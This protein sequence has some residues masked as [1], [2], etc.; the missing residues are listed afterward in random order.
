MSDSQNQ[1]HHTEL[2]TAHAV[3]SGSGNLYIGGSFAPSPTIPLNGSN[4]PNRHP[5]FVGRREELK[6]V[7]D[8]LASRAWI[9][10]IDGMGGIGKTTLAL[11]ATHLCKQRDANYPNVPEFT[12]YI[13]TSARDR[14][15]FSL[16]DVVREVL[17]VLSPF[18]A[19]MKQ[20]GLPEQ[21]S[22]AI[23]ALA[24]EPRLLIIDNFET[25]KDESLH[26]FLRDQLPNPSK[27]LITSR[28]HL[29]TGEK[30]VTIG[31]LE[32]EDAIQL[33]KLE[34]ARLNI[35]ISDQDITRLLIIAQ[36]SFGIPLV[37]R[38]AME[39]VYNGK[40]LE[41]V[42]ESLEDATAEDIFDY[43]F[44][45]SLSTL[46]IETRNI[47]RSMALLPTWGRI[48]TIAAMN[49]H[50]AAIQERVGRLVSLSLLDDN[51][52]LV[53]SDRRYQLPSFARYL[54]AKE[55]NDSED[56][57]RSPIEH[58]LQQYLIELQEHTRYDTANKYLDL[59]FINIGSIV[60]AASSLG[61]AALIE[62][63]I[64]TGNLIRRFNI[65]TA[66]VLF[67]QIIERIDKS[68]DWSL[69]VRLLRHLNPFAFGIPV[70]PPIFYGRTKQLDFIQNLLESG[71]SSS[72]FI[73]LIGPRR[74]G[75]TS[76]LL[77]L[78]K[79]QSTR[80]EYVFIDLQNP[81]TRGKN[82]FYYFLARSVSRV[83]HR[84][85]ETEDPTTIE[86][87][88]QDF[89]ESP[90]RVLVEYLERVSPRLGNR[91]LVLMLDELEY[92]F[93]P[94]NQDREDAIEIQALFRFMLQRGMISLITAGV[95][96]L[97]ELTHPDFVSPLFNTSMVMKLSFLDREDAIALITNPLT[98]LVKFKPEAIER[99][100]EL[101][102]RHPFLLQALGS[103]V[104][105]ICSEKEQLLV[106]IEIVNIAASRVILSAAAYFENMYY[107]VG[108]AGQAVLFAASSFV[109]NINETFSMEELGKVMGKELLAPSQ[110]DEA[111][112]QLLRHEIIEEDNDGAYR[113]TMDITRH[114]AAEKSRG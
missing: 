50:T 61:D 2:Q 31:G 28:H 54:A 60:K 92:L 42:V 5:N 113:F 74:I 43:I 45:L 107:Q 24:T 51:R 97:S 102:G 84:D 39:S 99:L 40:S 36:K 10:T 109:K 26:R 110:I 37:L 68:D 29:Q 85:I 78:N 90:G 80:C 17:Y 79:R 88:R 67:D 3:H 7:I 103:E 49:P 83:L 41:W 114:W 70:T 57:G 72:P 104:V 89:I 20:L 23:R 8:A 64:E 76:L 87:N 52:K 13:W 59:E 77:T 47:F 106:D 12:G 9:I 111:L 22:L 63:C 81:A 46:D 44:K 96:P 55:L 98:N 95:T 69:K 56:R 91:R 108:H 66:R 100:L 21:L 38:W 33:L 16:A 30:V 53:K 18:E 82:E 14:H 19:N 105:R 15:D 86:P 1:G 6:K 101:S 62:Q 71:R 65:D 73:H 4:L 48:E 27:V 112:R 25:V 75:K 35:A 58:A 34:A 32:E 94:R 11:E 93:H